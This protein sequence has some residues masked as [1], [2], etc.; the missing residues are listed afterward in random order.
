MCAPL[1]YVSTYWTPLSGH[2]AS[3]PYLVL[4]GGGQAI[5]EHLL[6]EH[7]GDAPGHGGYDPHPV[8]WAAAPHPDLVLHVLYEGLC[9]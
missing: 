8:S 5:V 3:V 2:G 9:G 7:G 4:E 6:V 1:C